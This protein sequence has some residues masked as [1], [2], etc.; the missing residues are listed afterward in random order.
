M[1]DGQ[2][3]AD[4]NTQTL[5]SIDAPDSGGEIGTQKAAIGCFISQ[6][7]HGCKAHVDGG[8][9]KIFLFEKESIAK[10]DRAVKSE[11]WF[12]PGSD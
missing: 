10:N 2:P 1:I 12:M 3:V 8:G 9:G 5:C 7:P 6:P 4:A 11:P